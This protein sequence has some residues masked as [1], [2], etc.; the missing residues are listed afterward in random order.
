[1]ITRS[2]T[3]HGGELVPKAIV[4]DYVKFMTTPG[5]HNDT[6]ANSTHRAFFENYHAKKPLDKCP[7]NDG[8]NVDVIDGMDPLPPVILAA[9]AKGVRQ[10]D[11]AA[12]IEQAA[13]D[14]STTLTKLMRDSRPVAE[15]YGP[16]FASMLHNVITGAA[17]LREECVRVGRKLRFDVERSVAS[18]R[19]PCVACESVVE[20]LGK[21]AYR[22]GKV[23]L[24]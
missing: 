6:Y 5:S 21:G 8:H 15:V 24:V 3:E 16:L 12:D 23:G 2:L 20:P 18:G 11:S 19:D 14:A 1:M 17:T 7:G 22:Q 13:C 10:G 9:T 4:D